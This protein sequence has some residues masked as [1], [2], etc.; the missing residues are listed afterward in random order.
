MPLPVSLDSVA[1]ELT[2]LT[3]DMT[4]F[5]NRRTGEIV[6]ISRD[7][8][9]LVEEE[10]AEDEL[11]DWQ[12]EMIP[13]VREIL[14]SDDWAALPTKFDVH[15]WEI[16]RKFADSVDDASLADR[17]HRAIRGK[18]AFRLFRITVDEA[19]LREEWYRFKHETLRQIA[20]DA[21]DDLGVPYR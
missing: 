16:M 19:G 5:V 21:L 12:K 3:D 15:E 11:P 13:K 7:D 1:E 17:L 4:A 8:A 14:S 2:I 10:N 20:R 18:G 9:D 6:S